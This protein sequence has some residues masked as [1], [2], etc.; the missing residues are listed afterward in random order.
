MRETTEGQIEYFSLKR[1]K[2]RGIFTPLTLDLERSICK[3]QEDYK[4]IKYTLYTSV[5]NKSHQ[6]E[7][8]SFFDGV[9]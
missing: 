7:L 1:V 2:R 4:V 3:P 8:I 5:K 9:S 6:A